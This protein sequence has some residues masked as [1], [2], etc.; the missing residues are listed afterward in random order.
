M[1]RRGKG[2]QKEAD[3][4]QDVD[5]E[6]DEPVD[7]D[8][9]SSSS[10][11]ALPTPIAAL[12]L[13]PEPE[14]EE[15]DE[16]TTLVSDATPTPDLAQELAQVKEQLATKDALLSSHQSTIS[17][18]QNALQ[19]QICLELLHNPY[20]ISPCGHVA[21]LDCLQQWFRNPPPNDGGEQDLPLAPHLR[22]KTCPCCRSAVIAR[23]CLS[24]VIKSTV[25]I[26]VAALPDTASAA[27]D[28]AA[29]AAAAAVPA[30]G[31]DGDVWAG[32][33]PP[34]KTGRVVGGDGGILDQE[35]GGIYRCEDCLYEIFG[36]ICAGCGRVYDGDYGDSDGPSGSD[37][38]SLIN[39]G[40]QV[41]IDDDPYGPWEE[42]EGSFIDDEGSD[43]EHE[44]G[45]APFGVG[46]GMRLWGHEADWRGDSE[47]RSITES[48]FLRQGGSPDRWRERRRGGRRSLHSDLGSGS[49]VG[50]VSD[51]EEVAPPPP[52]RGS[53]RARQPIVI[54]SDDEE[55][56]EGERDA[57][58]R[59]V[60]RRAGGS[61]G[62]RDRS[63]IVISSDSE[64]SDPHDRAG[65]S[66]HNRSLA[67]SVADRERELHGE[68]DFV[69]RTRYDSA[70]SDLNDGGRQYSRSPSADP[71]HSDRSERILSDWS[72]G[73]SDDGD[74][75]HGHAYFSDVRIAPR[76]SI[77]LI[78]LILAFRMF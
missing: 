44:P 62:R 51:V 61:G 57:G 2:K 78:L 54:S 52:P 16:E 22:R 59:A 25:A 53:R 1:E 50:S 20:T 71:S 40:I 17:N 41:R 65:P 12:A 11:R 67:Q 18:L 42:Y 37:V 75:G 70:E 26:L 27:D 3:G 69:T 14:T 48:E 31:A 39:G 10:P 38:D 49:D 29:A 74:G 8:A 32:I 34:V 73:G 58:Q 63:A 68:D 43:H 7:E 21:C 30:A 36:G 56:E 46:W 4:E 45:W 33:F 19:C 9:K 76:Y 28:E 23:P 60:V 5:I 47:E 15:P 24:Y 6:A 77:F 66:D 64:L 55:E 13:K 72:R 35:D